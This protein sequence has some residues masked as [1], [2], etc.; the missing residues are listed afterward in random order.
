MTDFQSKW[1]WNEKGNVRRTI[2]SIHNVPLTNQKE[3]IKLISD[4]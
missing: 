4:N 3:D 1:K 2:T